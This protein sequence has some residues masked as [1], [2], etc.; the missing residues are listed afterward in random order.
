MRIEQAERGFD[1][2]TYFVYR[3]LLDEELPNAEDVSRRIKEAFSAFPNW[4]A[5]EAALRDLR[6]KS[7]SRWSQA[8][9]HGA[10]FPLHASSG[11]R[12][13]HAARSS[14]YFGSVQRASLRR[15]SLFLSFTYC[16]S[17]SA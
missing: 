16:G 2:L 8:S 7:L 14:P 5:S 11:D 10:G 6:K 12:G 15:T 13:R 3:T 1:G 17:P 9:P 4:R